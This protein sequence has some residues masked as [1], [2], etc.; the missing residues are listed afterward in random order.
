MNMNVLE[1]LLGF[2]GTS[3]NCGSMLALAEMRKEA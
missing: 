1:R 3:R 2:R